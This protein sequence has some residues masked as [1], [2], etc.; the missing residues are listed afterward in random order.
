MELRMTTDLE[1]AL[2]A[3]IGFNF[4]EL[5]QDL[6]DRLHHYNTLVVTEDAIQDAKNDRA[7]L[8]KLRDAIDTHRKDVKKRYMQ[9]Y[10]V[11]EAKAKELTSLIDAPIA[12]I[13]GQV[14]AF[15]EQ[16]RNQ[17]RMEIE[18]LYEELVPE[19]YR[20][21]IPLDRILD[22]K[23]L[24]KSTTMKSVGEDIASL[25]KRTHVEV[26]YLEATVDPKH[27]T[28]VRAEYIRTLNFDKALDH[29]ERLIATEQAFQQR[30]AQRAAVQPRAEENQPVAAQETVVEP[31]P[32]P[33]KEEK[34][35]AL[36][37]EFHI[38]M[39]QANAL[40]QF[41]AAQ[42]INYMKI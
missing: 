29:K 34:L 40:K 24:N 19:A 23:W 28:A 18:S 4:E 13:D 16:Q 10:N 15:E 22:Q 14:K 20:D 17:K 36:R 38:T 9:P 8:R 26:S 27:L 2:P 30:E 1:T 33:S 32:Q 42:N 11:F 7:N 3:E 25:A 37:L 12:A 5:K 41:L 31:D 21:I 6:T 39:D 35:Y